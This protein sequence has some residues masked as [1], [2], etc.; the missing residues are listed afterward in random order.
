MASTIQ[1]D[2]IKDIGGN[3]MISS[4]GSGTFTSNLP[5]GV[6]LT[7]GVDNRL[8]TATSA[9]ALNGEARL[10]Y[11]GDVLWQEA[12]GTTTEFRQ[13][14]DGAGTYW[15][16]LIASAS[17]V[18]LYTRTNSPLKFGIN[19]AT[20][21]EID[22]SGNLVPSSTSTGVYLGVS[23]AT[24]ANLLDDYEEGTFTPAWTVAGG[25]SLGVAPS[26]NLGFYTK[27]GRMCTISIYSFILATSGTITSYS[28]TNLP[29][30]SEANTYGSSM[31]QEYGQT[32][33]GTLGMIAAS[34]TSVK[35]TK[36]DGGSPPA[37]AYMRLGITYQ[38]T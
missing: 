32:G 33:Q 4:N 19:N 9:T 35:I 28:C 10:R 30:T 12:S 14:V 27:V 2:N 24:A 21:W 25:G 29:F 11:D 5:A 31:G 18:K 36:Y 8:V 15:S 17:D 3:T 34:S 37:N 20:K 26:T 22:T 6:S 23:S 38:T 13:T 16:S 7:N 1:V